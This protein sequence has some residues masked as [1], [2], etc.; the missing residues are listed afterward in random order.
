MRRRRQGDDLE[1]LAAVDVHLLVL[2]AARLVETA[3]VPLPVLGD[4]RGVAVD[5]NG[6]GMRVERLAELR[7]AGLGQEIVVVEFHEDLAAR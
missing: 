1:Q 7:Q 5:E 2:P 4:L 3:L 6:L